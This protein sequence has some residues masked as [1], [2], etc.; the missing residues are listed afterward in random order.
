MARAPKPRDARGLGDRV[1]RPVA[2]ADDLSLQLCRVGAVLGEDGDH[3]ARSVAVQGREGPAQDFDPLRR[4]EAEAPRLTLP[5]GHGRGNPILIKPDA[6]DTEVRACAEAADRNLQVLGVVP[7]VGD[8]DAGDSRQRLG[9]I[10]LQLVALDLRRVDA[11]DGNRQIERAL[12][13]PRRADDDRIDPRDLRRSDPDA[14]R[15]Q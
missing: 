11:V 5:V 6:A 12:L 13:G 8:D 7:A 4:H 2:P 14:R 9:E 10:D 3:A 15:G 1:V